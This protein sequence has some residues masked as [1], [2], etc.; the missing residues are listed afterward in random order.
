MGLMWE[1][2]YHHKGNNRW[3]TS[4]LLTVLIPAALW[5]FMDIFHCYSIPNFP[6]MH[7]DHV[8]DPKPKYHQVPRPPPR[9]P[10][11]AAWAPA[12]CRTPRPG[13]RAPPRSCAPGRPWAPAGCWQR[14]GWTPPSWPVGT[15]PTWS[16]YVWP[17]TATLN[18]FF[19]MTRQ[20]YKHILAVVT[21]LRK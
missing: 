9:G 6:P 4:A 3:C 21:G 2:C 8:S 18:T 20:K 16:V 15:E 7:R 17:H 13:R 19:I 11:R 5:I 10:S 12:A 1:V 14:L